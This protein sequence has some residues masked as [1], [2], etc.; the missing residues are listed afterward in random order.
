MKCELMTFKRYKVL[1]FPEKRPIKKAI[2]VPM[3]SKTLP[4]CQ[5]PNLF[6][7]TQGYI[8]NIYHIS[9][10]FVGLIGLYDVICDHIFWLS[11]ISTIVSYFFVSI[12]P[13]GASLSHKERRSLR[14]TMKHR[15]DLIR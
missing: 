10:L 5:S 8:I 13:V 6:I 1:I 14:S 2:R 3:K 9:Q 12:Y 11:Y 7:D 15:N 4:C